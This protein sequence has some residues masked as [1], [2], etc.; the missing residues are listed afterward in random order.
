VVVALPLW[1]LFVWLTRVRNVVRDDGVGLG[2]VVP[3][4][5]V[6]LAVY[7]LVDRRRGT[8]P[9]ATATVLVWLV[10]L[11]FVFAHDHSAAFELVHTALAAVSVGLSVAAL[12]GSRAREASLSSRSG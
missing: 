10:R 4:G 2:V 1:T 6:A 3:L 12:R 11:P 5:L 7:A 9:L 8:V